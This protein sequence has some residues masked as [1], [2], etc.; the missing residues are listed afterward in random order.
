MDI[1]IL[2]IIFISSFFTIDKNIS[3]YNDYIFNYQRD[4]IYLNIKVKN[5]FFEIDKN[6]QQKT[7]SK[8]CWKKENDKSYILKA[9]IIKIL[10]NYNIK[11]F[12][13]YDQRH[14]P[15]FKQYKRYTSYA[16]GLKKE[17]MIKVSVTKKL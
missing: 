7:D 15:E 10:H 1:A 6:L 5:I 14:K 13:Q 8:I 9:G 16:I 17:H 12:Y 4:G 2:N 11:V 3:N